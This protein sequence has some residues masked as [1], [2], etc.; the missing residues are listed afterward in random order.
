M[1]QFLEQ[2]GNNTDDD[3]EFMPLVSIN[4]EKDKADSE[5]PDYK[6][7]MPILPLRNTVLFPGVVI[8]LSVGR[9]K[10][11]KAIKDAYKK[12]KYV[13]VLSQSDPDIEDPDTKDLFTTGTIARIVKLLK[14]PDGGTTVLIHGS[15]RFAVEQYT[16]AEP[17]FK[18]KI[19]VLPH[20]KLPKTREFKALITSLKD[21]S[22]QI[23]E[24]S[25]NI[26]SEVAVMLRNMDKPEFM[27]HFVSSHLNISIQEKQELLEI[28]DVQQRAEQILQYLATELQ[29]AQLKNDIQNRAR[30]DM[31][32]QQREY[33]LQQQLKTIQ[34][35]LGNDELGNDTHTLLNRA[36][37]KQWTRE[38]REAFDR[39]YNRL[40]RM[41]PMVPEY[42]TTIN[43]LELLLD[44]PWC[45]YTKDN[46]DL[47]R[48]QKVLDKDHYGLS[49][50]KQRII[51]HL[52]VLKLK[53]DMKAPIL[54]FVGPPGVGKTSL[55]KSIAKALKRQYARMSLGGLHDES[56]IRGHRRTYIGSMPGRIIQLLKKTKS[57]NPVI[58]LDE[59]DK[60]GSDFRGD[61]ASALLEVL[62]PEQNTTFHD[63][64]LEVEYDLSKVLFIATA[65]TLSTIHPALRDRMEIIQV[66]GYSL[67]EKIAIAKQHLVP[68][69]LAEHALKSKQIKISDAIIAKVI[70]EY[71]R[72]SGV[73]TLERRIAALMRGVAKSVAMD[74][75][76][77]PKITAND[78]ERM[79]GSRRHDTELYTDDN[80][81]GVSVGLAWTETGGDILF[82]ETSLS[83][84]KGGLTL[85]GNL[86]DVMKESATTTLS[87]IRAHAEQLGID[88]AT[89]DTTNIHVHVPEGG[90]PKDGPSA[91]IALL[92]ALVSALTHRKVKPYLAMTGEITL[93]GKVLPVGGI[94]EKV[95]AAKRAGIRQVILCEANRRNVAEIN[96]EYIK[97]LDFTYVRNM[98]EVCQLALV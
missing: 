6:E 37:K 14:M 60:V 44:L 68:K 91:G 11:I 84:G 15:D 89:F 42:S 53:N 86:G 74:E 20:Q 78:V 69:Q 95:L 57:S 19:Q 36:S 47:Q 77:D 55:G 73:R 5:P 98:T 23:I 97:G 71:T 43:Y 59:I 66:S 52:A 64:Y 85:T 16:Q 32:K 96:P 46:F 93:R 45:D 67:E 58:I 94:K 63:N 80:P 29:V 39:E 75:N 54:C 92:T 34:E 38:S 88:H 8:P 51:E 90:I 4:D 33:Y 12:D 76:Y 2:F 35:E 31:D 1:L 25:S 18:A 70:G 41:N 50:I 21:L 22:M 13:G 56:E 61:P 49:K 26:P 30:N 9:E 40:Q 79:L 48:A 28:N 87:Y 81:P 7:E 72:E 82:I 17:F 62:D 24:L 65:N 83:K 27:L 10:S 3:V